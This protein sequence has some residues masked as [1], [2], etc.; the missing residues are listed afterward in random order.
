MQPRSAAMVGAAMALSVGGLALCSQRHSSRELAPA[1][2]STVFARIVRRDRLG[3]PEKTVFLRDAA[4]SRALAVALGMDA[5]AIGICPR[6][7]AIADFGIVLNGRTVYEKRQVYVFGDGSDAGLPA[8]VV[9][10]T[11]SGCRI[12]PPADAKALVD[13]LRAAGAL[14]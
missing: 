6:D 3:L 14:P 12:G 10:V 9:S 2:E 5:H 8:S 13:K 7:Y 4:S 11:S 1:A